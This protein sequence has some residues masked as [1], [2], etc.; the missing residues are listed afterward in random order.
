[1]LYI[2]SGLVAS[3]VAVDDATNSA[4]KKRTLTLEVKDTPKS[5]IYCVK[6][7]IKSHFSSAESGFVYPACCPLLCHASLG[8]L[9]RATT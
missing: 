2:M 4:A 5:T 9:L 8:Y 1:M 7:V 3:A 6:A